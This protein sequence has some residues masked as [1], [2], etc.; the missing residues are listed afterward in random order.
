MSDPT[1][2]RAAIAAGARDGAAFRLMLP[3][4]AMRGAS[5]ER[6][7]LAA[8]SSLDFHDY[9]EYQPGDDLRRLDW[10]A[11]ARSDKQIVKL[12]REEVSPKLEIILDCS[13]S[14]DP[15]D[16]PKAA[17]ALR[18]A[19]ALA[20]AAGNSRCACAV[21]LAGEQLALMPGSSDPPETWETPR[22]D[23]RAL[24]EFAAAAFRSNSIRV[25]I[26]DLLWP[27][28]PAPLLRSLANRA[29]SFAALQALSA[30]EE[31]PAPSGAA[32]LEDAETGAELDI[33]VDESACRAY[34]AALRAHREEWSRACRA[35]GALFL[36]LS[37]ENP[38]LMPLVAAG[39]LEP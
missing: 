37:A 14:M 33:V 13:R 12:F 34:R 15:Q 39:L 7:G 5:G 4:E 6:L 29:A 10:S 20:A 38:S 31:N 18:L 23:A 36:P 3:R 1:A 27:A 26:S 19:A 25:L 8:G 28:A 2:H 24:P 32:R 16:S 17:A 35:A 11:Y 21:W 22:F 9:R 30:E